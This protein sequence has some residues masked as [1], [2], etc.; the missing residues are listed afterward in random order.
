MFLYPTSIGGSL[1]LIFAWVCTAWQGNLRVGAI[2]RDHRLKAECHHQ[3]RVSA[4]KMHRCVDNIDVMDQKL[5]IIPDLFDC[6]ARLVPNQRMVID[7]IHG[8]SVELSYSQFSVLANAGAIS[9]Q[10]LG[11][12]ANDCV[13]M[14]SENSYKWLVMDQ[15]VMKVGAHNSVRGASAPLDELDYIYENS[16]SKGLVV[17]NVR[18]LEDMAKSSAWKNKPKFIIVLFAEKSDGRG[19][20]IQKALGPKFE[21]V[22]ILTYEEFIVLGE[23]ENFHAPKGIN[24]DSTA[25]ILY[26]SGTTSKPKGVVL[27]H[28]NLLHQVK[29][30][31]FST[32]NPKKWNPSVGDTVVSILPCW[33]IYER[34]SEYYCF[35]R[36][37][38]QVY[39]NLRNFKSDLVQWKPHYLFAVPR[40]F[41][42]IYKG[43]KSKFKKESAVKRKLLAA[44]TSL[45]MLFKQ[46]Q[47]IATNKTV[48][49]GNPSRI[50][51]PLKRLVSAYYTLVL[52]PWH[53]LADLLA[54]SKVRSNLGGRLKVATS[55][56][57][58]LP[59]HIE[60]F[61]Q[62]IGI[63]IIVGFGLTESSPI[64]LSRHVEH[65]VIGSVGVPGVETDVKVVDVQSGRECPPGEIGLLKA[66]G[67]SI[68][69][70]Y[71]NNPAATAAAID[72]DGYFDTGDLARVN[73]AT[74][75]IVITGRAK[76]TIVLSN[77]ENVPPQPI[78]DRI[79]GSGDLIDQAMLVGQDHAFLA[80]V[81]VL[82]PAG[83]RA[84]GLVS[85]EEGK[86]LEATVGATPMTTGPA[87]D[88]KI[89]KDAGERLAVDARVVTEVLGELAKANEGTSRAWETVGSAIITLEPFSV[90]NGQLT[91]TLKVKRDVVSRRY[92]AD[93][94]KVY[95]GRK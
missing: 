74:G 4:L 81:V 75:D 73:T 16:G 76:D 22:D 90:V 10:E 20:D 14:F 87:G 26:T 18:L 24:G 48:Y 70:Q 63:N 5:T 46:V 23:K 53:K 85:E 47:A 94:D 52:W 15:A 37:A 6:T 12:K 13:S 77:G 38:Q 35:A 72:T 78:E 84:R 8:E 66:R 64:I 62:M 17:E 31:T 60:K 58:L 80:S 67:P 61:F 55:G 36:G 95:S 29:Y 92:A 1:V 68:L 59:L 25:T 30:N 91:Q 51:N 71:K 89:L 7:P 65:N 79:T 21:G 43:V 40:L 2:L 93:V 44:F 45:S 3:P 57:S 19:V 69:T 11:L 88:V 83:L 86:L 28:N 39:S 56:G 82:S 27:T 54:W 33:H 41:E 50:L 9:L 42:T 49:A 34:T 32:T